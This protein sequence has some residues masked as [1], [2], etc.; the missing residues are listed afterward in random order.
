MAGDKQILW[1][2]LVPTQHKDGRPIHTRFHRVWDGKVRGLSG[3]L[4]IMKPVMGQWVSPDESLF[5]ERMIPVRVKCTAEDIDRIADMTA[6]YY[7]QE[8]VMYYAISY[9]VVI[10][11]YKHKKSKDVPDRR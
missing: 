2:I 1:E 6:K 11:N 8:A 7:D 5:K 10:K 9:V 3:G 4:T